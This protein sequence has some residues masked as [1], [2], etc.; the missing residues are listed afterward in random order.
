MIKIVT[1]SL[2]LKN[3]LIINHWIRW[4][5]NNLIY[6]FKILKTYWIHIERFVKRVEFSKQT[7]LRLNKLIVKNQHWRCNKAIMGWL[8]YKGQKSIALYRNNLKLLSG[9]M[10]LRTWTLL[11]YQINIKNRTWTW[12]KKMKCWRII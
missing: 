12:M 11:W 4:I 3:Y 8:T 2:S 1:K 6:K 10:I 5:R 7:Y 9:E